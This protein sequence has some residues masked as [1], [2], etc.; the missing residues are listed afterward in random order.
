MKLTYDNLN[1]LIHGKCNFREEYH[2]Q[3]FAD[4]L[5][6]NSSSNKITNPNSKQKAEIINPLYN[7]FVV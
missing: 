1:K 4:F 3:I 6:A 5:M 7:R 2:M